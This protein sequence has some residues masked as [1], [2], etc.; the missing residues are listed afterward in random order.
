[1]IILSKGFKLP[2]TGDFGDVWFPAL[3]DNIQQL[4]DHDHNGVNSP[5]ISAV[6]LTGY[7]D[8]VLQ[9]A[10]IDQGNGY[11]R[12]L[13]SVPG[14]LTVDNFVITVKD[15]TTKDIMYLK[16]EKFNASSYYL[17]TNSPQNVEVYYGV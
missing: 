7:V 12:A 13:I 3:E 4:N 2:E 9:A 14:G 11:Y 15:P 8:T 17:F 10:F 6:A 1:M 5:K 16:Q